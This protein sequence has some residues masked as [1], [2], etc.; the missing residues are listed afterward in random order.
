MTPK[1]TTIA[2]KDLQ[3]FVQDIFST[4][5]SSKAEAE[6]IA[7]Y[8]LGANLAGHDSH[9][10]IRVSR[11]IQLRREGQIVP[12]QQVDILVDTPV[13]SVV[14]GKYGFGQTVGP[15]AVQIGIDKC[16]A[17]GLAAVSLRNSGH[18]GRIGDWAEMAAN[19]GLVSI[20]FVNAA[21][22]VL[23]APFGSVERRFS[24]APYCV[25]V[26]IPGRAPVL[27]DFA[28]SLV[29]EGK[30]FVASQGG[31]PIP[32]DALISDEGRTSD[33]SRL[34]YGDYVASGKRDIRQGKGALRAFGEHKGSG[35]ALVCELLG[36]ALTGN[37]C[38]PTEKRL[39]NGMLSIYI[40]PGKL[41]PESLFPPEAASYV[42][43]VKAAKP[44]QPGGETLVPGEPEE[45]TRK[46]R[47]ATGIQL[48]EET[49]NLLLDSARAVGVEAG[50][51]DRLRQT[52]MHR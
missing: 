52:T 26:P 20:H 25:G 9:G 51:I 17:M 39:S 15:Q 40:D 16:K 11:Y 38:A 27:L 46:E 12:D 23:V 29:A 4:A 28:T 44:A 18:L 36:G 30:V 14:D 13:L 45:R 21:G 24:T 43:Y 41:D 35:L 49:W 42:A 1:T 19:A 31:K 33:D 47:L 5:G 50:R 3:E 10:V 48:A 22:S 7:K 6:R 37:G 8:L 2:A 32:A 34:L